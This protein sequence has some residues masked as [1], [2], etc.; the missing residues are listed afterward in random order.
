MLIFFSQKKIALFIQNNIFFFFIDSSGYDHVLL[1]SYLVPYLYE[2][3]QLPRMEKRGNKVTQIR[4]F[5]EFLFATSLSFSLPP[6]TSDPSASCSI[7]SRPR[8]T[9]LSAF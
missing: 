2:K 9:F 1:E 4:T 7:S 8:L 6:P 5:P 3:K